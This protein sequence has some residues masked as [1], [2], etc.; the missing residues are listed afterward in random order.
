[1]AAVKLSPLVLFL[2][3]LPW[4]CAAETQS[5]LDS[6]S[7]AAVLEEVRAKHDVPALGA[8]IVT[9]EGPVL[10]EVVGVRKR[11]DRTKAQKNDMFHLGSCT[12]AF[13][14]W[15]AGW[16]VENGK[17]RWDSTLGEIFP[18]QTRR[19]PESHKNITLEQ[20]LM[21]RSGIEAD[22]KRDRL[23]RLP[24]G[25]GRW[26]GQTREKINGRETKKQ[27]LDFV[28]VSDEL[29]LS[30][31]PGTTYAYSNNNQILAAAMIEEVTGKPWEDLLEEL[32]YQPLGMKEVGQGPMGKPGLI[33]QPWQHEDNGKPIAPGP[34]A[35]NPEVM[36]PSGRL[37][38]SLDSWSRF[39]AE[40]VRGSRGNGKLLGKKTYEEL[41][42][43]P[44][45]TRGCWIPEAHDNNGQPTSFA[46]AGSNTYNHALAR[47]YPARNLAILVVTNQGSVENTPGML[48]CIE[49]QRRLSERL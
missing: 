14:G 44:E 17:L 34:G 47:I 1:L 4:P 33:R 32:V 36:G 49:L 31:E 26:P 37:H 23:V 10:I 18:P 15:L 28:G 24:G 20:L 7:L 39:V 11:G 35:D 19:W 9:E 41:L 48:A 13:T 29:P 42:D 2:A 3:L 22:A 38:M 5:G 16:A 6:A 40:I 21:H 30:S 8:A 12:K 46:H 27:R 25:L 43:L 45:Y